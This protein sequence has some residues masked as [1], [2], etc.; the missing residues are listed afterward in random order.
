MKQQWTGVLECYVMF[1]FAQSG[2]TRGNGRVC[3]KPN[4]QGV[5]RSAI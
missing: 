4:T 5:S 3:F 2:S 1:G